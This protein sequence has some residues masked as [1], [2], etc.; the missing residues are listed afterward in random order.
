MIQIFRI[1]GPGSGRLCSVMGPLVY[2]GLSETVQ[3]RVTERH[4]GTVRFSFS[5]KWLGKDPAG[6]GSAADN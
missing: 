4:D 3:V 2:D 1:V 6:D 5:G